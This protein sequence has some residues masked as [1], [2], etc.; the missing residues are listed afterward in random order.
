MCILHTNFNG[1]EKLF[2]IKEREK[3]AKLYN[4]INAQ[5]FF[6]LK[7]FTKRINAL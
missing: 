5:N 4:K 3:I 7:K 1:I 2:S 6:N